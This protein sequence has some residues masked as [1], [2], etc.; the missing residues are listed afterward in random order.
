MKST[1]KIKKKPKKTKEK[2]TKALYLRYN[3]WMNSNFL[4]FF[5]IL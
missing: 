5:I 1:K 2:K 3:K 4:I